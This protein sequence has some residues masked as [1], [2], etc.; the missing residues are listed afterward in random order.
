MPANDLNIFQYAVIRFVPNVEREEF[1]NVGLIMYSK[2]ARYIRMEYRLCVEKYKS[3]CISGPDYDE[4]I[5]VLANMKDISLG[6]RQAGPIAALDLS[7]RFRWLTAVRST[8]I[9][10]SSAHPG[11]SNDLDATFDRLFNEL[12]L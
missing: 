6:N 8:V 4:V 11:K 12:V 1:V 3:I 5:T 10:S 2:K 9:Q 7:E